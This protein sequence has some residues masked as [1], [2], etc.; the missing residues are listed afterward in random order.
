MS[1]SGPSVP[2]RPQLPS[3]PARSAPTSVP[4]SA[5]CT[6][7][8]WPA[9]HHPVRRLHEP[10]ERGGAAGPAGHRRRP[11]RRCRPEARPVRGHHQRSLTRSELRQSGFVRKRARRDFNEQNTNNPHHHGRLRPAAGDGGQRHPRRRHAPAG[12]VFRGMPTPR[13]GPPA[14]TWACRTG[15]WA[16]ARWA[17]PTSAPAGWC[18]RTCPGSPKPLPTGALMKI[19]PTG[20]P[21][22]PAWR[23]ARPCT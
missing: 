3:R 16:T 14:W 17:T 23:R 8:G 4:P 7:P 22:T 13:S 1:P 19:P 11:D 5:A 9:R 15:R 18:S 10:Q 2:A 6:A 20:T 12:P 21:W